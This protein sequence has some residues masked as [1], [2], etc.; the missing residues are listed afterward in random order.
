MADAL[1]LGLFAV[2]GAQA[3]EAAGVAPLI[4]VIMGMM[5]GTFGGLIRDVLTTEI[6]LILRPGRLY[7]TAAALGP[8]VYLGAQALGAASGTALVLGALSTVALRF[9]A[10]L[11]GLRLPVFVVEQVPDDDV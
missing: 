5:T 2:S 4:V 11:F 8:V 10:I 7:A 3:A 6:P 1:G 9:A